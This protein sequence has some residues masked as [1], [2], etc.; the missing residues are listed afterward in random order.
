MKIL[1]VT[2][3]DIEFIHALQPEG[4]SDITEAFRFYLN[5]DFCNPIKIIEDNTIVG[6]GNSTIFKNTGWLAHIIVHKDY[7]NK[8]IGS[9]IVDALLNNLLEKSVQTAL[10]IAT[11]LGEPIYKKAGFRPVSDY[12]FFKRQ[13]PWIEIP[14]SKNISSYKPTHYNSM[15][16]L[17][18][19]ISGED[20]E[21]LIKNHLKDAIVYLDDGSVEGFYLPD[22]GEGLILAKT[23]TAGIEL[24]KLKYASTADR[25]VIPSENHVGINF[26]RHHGFIETETKGKR[27]VRGKDIGWK[28]E[29]LFS[30][31][32]GNLG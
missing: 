22:L 6:L 26:L 25:A 13:Q 27:M 32:G 18:K 24:M 20:R 11:E 28:P 30:R 1:K 19:E 17:D 3:H 12:I 5:L 7:R 15:I 14:I 21:P 10:L 8:G 9:N 31:I 23:T 16:E 4:W 29:S 2:Y